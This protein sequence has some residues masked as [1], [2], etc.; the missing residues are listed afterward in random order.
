[1]LFNARA[2]VTIVVDIQQFRF[3]FQTQFKEGTT[4]SSELH[5]EEGRSM[6]WGGFEI[7]QAQ[8]SLQLLN[9]RQSWGTSI[10]TSTKS[11]L[12]CLL[13]NKYCIEHSRH[14]A[15]RV[16]SENGRSKK[17]DSKYPSVVK[18]KIRHWHRIWCHAGKWED[19]LC[20]LKSKISLNWVCKTFLLFTNPTPKIKRIFLCSR[21]NFKPV[22]SLFP[23]SMNIK[24][25]KPGRK[26]SLRPL[27]T[28]AEKASKAEETDTANLPSD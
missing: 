24:K 3:L 12:I 14:A 23:Q 28:L 16:L 8:L 4:S 26:F 20:L 17:K 22:Q 7:N 2:D 6:C 27:S 13:S 18:V 10:W 9:K 15:I 21:I 11:K 25:N 5:K 19:T 1:M